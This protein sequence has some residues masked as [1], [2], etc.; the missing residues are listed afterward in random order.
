MKFPG[1]NSPWSRSRPQQRLEGP[2]VVT[3]HLLSQNP[4]SGCAHRV[5]YGM[6]WPALWDLWVEAASSLQALVSTSLVATPTLL[7]LIQSLHSS[8]KSHVREQCKNPSSR[9]FCGWWAIC[10]PVPQLTCAPP[11]KGLSSQQSAFPSSRVTKSCRD[12]RAWEISSSRQ[13][14]VETNPDWGELEKISFYLHKNNSCLW[15]RLGRE[16]KAKGSLPRE[17]GF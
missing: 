4:D 6:Q 10:N 8:H 2:W 16:P 15:L 7:H 1:A 9:P 12:K 17:T 13:R 14:R 11:W 3:P 5:L